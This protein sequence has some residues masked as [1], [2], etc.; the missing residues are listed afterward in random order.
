M[1]QI[2]T[3]HLVAGGVKPDTAAQWA[4]PL[5][6]A[7]ERFRIDTPERQAM[8]LANVAHE[9][10]RFTR[11]RENMNY[12]SESRLLQIFGKR[13]LPS[14]A[15]RF[16]RNPEGLAN[17][18]YAGRVGNGNEASGDGWRFRGG[19]PMGLTFRGNYRECG[20]GIGALLE[21]CPE[22]I[23]QPP[24]GALS[25]AWYWNDQ[26]LNALADAG[27]FDAVCDE[28]NLGRRTATVGDAHGYQDRLSLLAAFRRAL[29]S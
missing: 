5:N 13:I 25:A 10:A 19:G 21:E 7:M 12:T 6:R 23:E 20:R 14:E 2:E 3:R 26:N 1:Q 18:V 28:I 22:L 15:K 8:F 29:R 24:I 16:L 4:M 11:G 9:S 27:N 17:R